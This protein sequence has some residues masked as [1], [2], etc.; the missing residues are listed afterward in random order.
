MASKPEP[1]KAT[2]LAPSELDR[3]KKDLARRLAGDGET[4]EAHL[5]EYVVTMADLAA[6]AHKTTGVFRRWS[7]NNYMF[8]EAQ[9]RMLGENHRGLY[10][11]VAQW[12]LIE[13][14]VRPDAKPKRIWVPMTF[15]VAAAATPT[16]GA[17]AATPPAPAP[18]ANAAPAA[19]HLTRFLTQEVYDW[20]DTFALNPDFVEPNWAAPLSSGDRATLDAL[21]ASSPVPVTF[22]DI[23]ARSENGFLNAEGITVDLTLP[24]GNQIS[25]LAHELVHHH[26]G[27]LEDLTGL[28]K[29]SVNADEV[30]ARCEQEAG[31]G[32]WLVMLMLGLGEEVGNEVT[33]AA[34]TYLRSWTNDKGEELEGHK[35][36]LKLLNARLNAALA[37]ANSVVAGYMTTASATAVPAAAH[38]AA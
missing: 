3:H 8:L 9:R 32:E 13:R 18:A 1:R 4:G 33:D 31:L 23:G 22:R 35:G 34:A 12:A 25:V 10:A 38:S 17:T 14:Q 24:L 36:R 30:R 11:G 20:S 2:K 7:A 16:P 21:V 5:R 37:A 27:H 29:G 15:R 28:R 26:L 19:T 6:N